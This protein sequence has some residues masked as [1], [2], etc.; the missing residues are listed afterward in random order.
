MPS[1]VA[2]RQIHLAGKVQGVGFR[3]FVY[4]LAR[5]AGLVGWVSN[6][7]DGV[8][9]RVQGEV[10]ALERFW[11]ALLRDHPPIATV[12]HAQVREA[13]LGTDSA[14]VV[15]ESSREGRATVLLLP[16]LDLC[17]SCHGEMTDPR[18]R[19]FQYPFITCTDCG[20]RYSIIQG[21]PYDRE[22]TTMAPFRMCPACA[23][24]YGDPAD[25]RFY[26]Q[27]NSCHA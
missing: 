19:R 2:A 26:S 13:E 5:E 16:D 14:F 20:P 21:L 4:R 27:T 15:R 12:T 24:E 22:R 11:S 17:E 7:L 18:N 10:D 3:P 6:G 1:R 25:R 23:R 9:I 8:H